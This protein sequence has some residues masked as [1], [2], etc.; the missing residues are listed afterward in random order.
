V[1]AEES[2]AGG[3]QGDVHVSPEGKH[4]HTAAKHNSHRPVAA[5]LARIRAELHSSSSCD[6]KTARGRR[7]DRALGGR[8]PHTE[9]Q[10]TFS[11][12]SPQPAGD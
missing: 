5:H 2:Q 1:H 6:K 10:L 9:L 11:L 3:L 8:S 7:A 4:P 12:P